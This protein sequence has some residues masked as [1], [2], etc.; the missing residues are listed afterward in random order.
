MSEQRRDDVCWRLATWLADVRVMPVERALLL[1]GDIVG[2]TKSMR[3][4][5][6]NLAH[7]HELFFSLLL[8]P[9]PHGDPLEEVGFPFR[10]TG[11]DRRR[12]VSRQ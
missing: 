12:D 9:K 8:S 11:I 10:P 5:R 2:Y 6:I 7:S 4:H 3:F 1:L